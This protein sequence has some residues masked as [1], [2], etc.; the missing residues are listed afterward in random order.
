MNVQQEYMDMAAESIKEAE[1]MYKNNFFRGTV[2]RAYYATFYAAQ[3]ALDRINVSAKFH[4]GV[5]ILFNK[6]FIETK[7][8][9]NYFNQFLQESLNQRLIGDYEIGY[10]ANNEQAKKSIENAKEIYKGIKEYLFKT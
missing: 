7:I 8:F 1:L 6:H 2:S 10:K 9:P 4:Q 5:Q 3:A